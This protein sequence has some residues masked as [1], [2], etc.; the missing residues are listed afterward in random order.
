VRRTPGFH[1]FM[2]ERLGSP[3][4]PVRFLGNFFVRPLCAGTF[5]GFWRRWNP[6]FV[7]VCLFYVYRPLRRLLPRPAAAFATFL[8]S[9]F[10]LHDV[11][12]GD[13]IDVVMGRPA[14]PRVTLLLGIFGCLALLTSALRL[15]VADYPAWFRAGVYLSLLA[16]GFG[17]R[18]VLLAWAS[19]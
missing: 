4:R 7:Y 19:W 6:P 3:S 15:D 2:V 10:V 17:L 1:E 18:W 16:I 8:L 11:P 12:F 9:G 13:G 14:V 5:A